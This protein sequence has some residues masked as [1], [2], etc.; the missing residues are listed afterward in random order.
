MHHVAK[1]NAIGS[2]LNVNLLYISVQR[3]ICHY[4]LNFQARQCNFICHFAYFLQYNP[5]SHQH[6]FGSR[7]RQDQ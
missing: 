6:C 2:L 4:T 3:Q 1:T 5:K 7:L